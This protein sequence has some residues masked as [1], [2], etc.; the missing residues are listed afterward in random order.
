MKKGICLVSIIPMRREP[1]EK[2]EMVS[3]LLFGEVYEISEENR[4]WYKIKTEFDHY[5]GWMD[6][7]LFTPVSAEYYRKLEQG[8]FSVLSAPVARIATPG[9]LPFYITAGSTLGKKPEKGII[10]TDVVSVRFLDP[11]PDS[12]FTSDQ[13]FKDITKKFLNSPYLWGGRSLFGLDCSGFTQIVYKIKGLRLPRDASQQANT[14]EAVSSLKELL[15]GDL[16]FFCHNDG[17]VTHTGIALPPGK[18]IH[19][20]GTVR[21]DGLDEKGIYNQQLGQYTHRLH[22]VRRMTG[23]V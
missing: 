18:I 8:D 7:K 9:G 19:C 11:L 17:S 22:S 6:R 23:K 15:E 21:I 20:S 3:Q 1:S 4:A 5:A 16:V 14:G 10:E 2:S 12:A 13:E